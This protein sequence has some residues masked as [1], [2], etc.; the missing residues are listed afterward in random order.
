MAF[1]GQSTIRLHKEI[2]SIAVAK[3]L[4]GLRICGSNK[5]KKINYFCHNLCCYSD[6]WH[7]HLCLW[8]FFGVTSHQSM[9]VKLENNILNSGREVHYAARKTVGTIWYCI[10]MFLKPKSWLSLAGFP[11][12]QTKMKRWQPLVH[13]CFR[14]RG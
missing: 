12:T 6:F 4:N 8:S 2:S 7:W 11:N 10:M 1:Y 5:I 9:K 13:I 14:M 3:S